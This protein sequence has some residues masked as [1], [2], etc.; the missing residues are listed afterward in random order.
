MKLE[1]TDQE[2]QVLVE[3]I[4]L[5]TK[6]GGIQVAKVAVPIVDKIME[7]AKQGAVD[8]NSAS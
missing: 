4:D 1:L 6:T 2:A 7:A 8:T 3:L 5:A